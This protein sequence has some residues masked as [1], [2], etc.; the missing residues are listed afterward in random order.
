MIRWVI[1]CAFT[2]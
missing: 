1:N 2:S